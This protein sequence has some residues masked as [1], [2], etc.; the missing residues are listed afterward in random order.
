MFHRRS[1][2]TIFTYRFGQQCRDWFD[3][4]P[5]TKRFWFFGSTRHSTKIIDRRSSG[6]FTSVFLL[7]KGLC[8]LQSDKSRAKSDKIVF[9]T[10]FF[11][12]SVRPRSCEPPLEPAPSR[13]PDA[14]ILRILDQSSSAG[15]CLTAGARALPPSH[16]PQVLREHP[17]PS[18]TKGPSFPRVRFCTC[19]LFRPLACGD[20]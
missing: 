10:F 14:G 3:N 12:K 15:H 19:W 11:F 20:R 6:T 5:N 16:K 1:G 9:E 13:P 17:P 4:K 2:C 8:L 7:R 18:A